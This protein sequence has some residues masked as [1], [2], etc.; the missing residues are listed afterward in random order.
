[1]FTNQRLVFCSFNQSEISILVND[2]VS[3]TE[4][5][6]TQLGG[7]NLLVSGDAEVAGADQEELLVLET[8]S[9]MCIINH[10]L[11]VESHPDLPLLLLLLMSH[12]VSQRSSKAVK[13]TNI[14]SVTFKQWIW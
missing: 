4:L 7:D 13:S 14:I 9:V 12:S 2:P 10:L 8:T 5:E 11:D 1:M 6:E 3:Q